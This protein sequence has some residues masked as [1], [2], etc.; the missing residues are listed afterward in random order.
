MAPRCAIQLLARGCGD[1]D[2]GRALARH[3]PLIWSLPSSSAH[4]PTSCVYCWS[5]LGQAGTYSQIS[6]YARKGSDP[7]QFDGLISTFVVEFGPDGKD[8]LA[9]IGAYD[10]VY[11]TL[12]A[13][14]I[15]VAI[16]GG[17]GRFL[18]ATGYMDPVANGPVQNTTGCVLFV[19]I[20][21]WWM[22][23]PVAAA[24]VSHHGFGMGAVCACVWW[25][26]WIGRRMMGLCCT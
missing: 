14:D 5:G 19:Q 22:P 9:F 18:G 13:T 10:L 2:A 3:L 1:V 11:N 23:C 21:M 16:T 4:Q 26:G 20:H 17:T 25:K 6:T 7:S 24:A 8:T 12:N 15:D